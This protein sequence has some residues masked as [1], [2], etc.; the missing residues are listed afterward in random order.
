[1]KQYETYKD[2]GIQWLGEIPSHWELCPLKFNLSLK[3]RIG[4]N[5][6]KSDEF[7]EES[8]A[9]L[10]TGQDFDK[11]DIDWS[12]CYQIDRE[13]YEED[14]FIQL[15]NGDLLVTKDGT[16]G[17]VAK[18]S[19]LDKPACLNS[20]IF[21]VKQIK[22][23]FEQNFLYWTFVSNQ[24]LDFNNF[25]STGSTIQHLY[26]NVFE[27]MPLLIPSL[28]EQQAIASYL[29]YKVGQIDAAIKEKEAM[30]EE[31]KAYRTAI[32][33]ETVTKGLDKNVLLV[34]SGISWL[35]KCPTNW[36]VLPIKR[37]ATLVRG[38]SPRP[39]EKFLT[40]DEEGYNWIKIG[41]AVKGEKYIT[42]TKQ[43]IIPKGLSA[44]R[45]VHKGDLILSN[46]MS[47]G[48]P[49]IL[50]IDGCIHDGWL[51]L[52]DFKEVDKEFMYYYLMSSSCANQ[53][54]YMVD[55]GVVQN[56]N[57][58]KVGAAYIVVPPLNE[59]L[60]I[61]RYLDKKIHSL[62]EAILEVD[63]QI[64]DLKSYKSSVISEAVTGKVDL[65]EWKCKTANA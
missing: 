1:M 46:S 45:E 24:L 57:I 26:Q 19:N 59:Q 42:S 48:Q 13:R 12:K 17:K 30:L 23:A 47:F 61:V 40:E 6:L 2:S 39:I 28:S 33:S 9:Y 34:D 36:I 56:L 49:Y 21:V 8:Y 35:G 16:I 5:G 58:E 10:V 27:N 4:W 64:A 52:S 53:F 18:V 29:D 51:A 44:T 25:N 37:V 15:S 55:G 3:G 63:G 54:A 7:K 41:D 20:G 32:I 65:R 14:P 60:D 43:R 38:G 31:L 22:S 62:E 11:A 50:A